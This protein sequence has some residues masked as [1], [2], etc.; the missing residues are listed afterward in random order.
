MLRL[1]PRYPGAVQTREAGRREVAAQ[2]TD[3][4]CALGSPRSGKRTE[5]QRAPVLRPEHWPNVVSATLGNA[6]VQY[7]YQDWYAPKDGYYEP[8]AGPGFGYTLD[9]GKIKSRAEL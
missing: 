6:N 5:Q 9:D 1:P 2:E 8:P 4:T 7:F 3:N